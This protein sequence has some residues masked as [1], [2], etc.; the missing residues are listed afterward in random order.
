MN[1]Q[2]HAHFRLRYG[3]FLF[4]GGDQKGGLQSVLEAAKTA[5]DDSGVHMAAASILMNEDLLEQARGEL[6]RASSF[7]PGGSAILDNNWGCYFFRRK[8]YDTAVG[9]FRKAAEASPATA[10]YHRNLVLALKSAGRYE[11]AAKALD[12]FSGTQHYPRGHQDL[13]AEQPQEAGIR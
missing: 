12:A 7:F 2:I 8:D 13:V 3:Q 10:L 6:D 1:R 11:E 9:F 5:S 4:A